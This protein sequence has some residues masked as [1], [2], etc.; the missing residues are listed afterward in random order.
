MYR[1]GEIQ[2]LT[3]RVKV[4]RE[5][6]KDLQRARLRLAGVECELEDLM[7]KIAQLELEVEAERGDVDALR[8]G[9]LRG[10]ILELFG[11]HDSRLKAE[12][13]ELL[14]AALIYDAAVEQRAAAQKQ[15]TELVA[16]IE[17]LGDVLG[18]A[19]R[20]YR[21]LDKYV[22]AHPDSVEALEADLTTM[23]RG[24]GPVA[25]VSLRPEWQR[26]MDA[27]RAPVEV[28]MPDELGPSRWSPSRYKAIAALTALSDDRSVTVLGESRQEH[29]RPSSSA[30]D[31]EL[32]QALDAAGQAL[33][34][35]T[36][37]REVVLGE[38]WK[39]EHARRVEQIT[40]AV[41][42]AQTSLG[43]FVHEVSDVYLIYPLYGSF[44]ELVLAAL[45]TA[46]DEKV[47]TNRVEIVRYINGWRELL[48]RYAVDLR[49]KVPST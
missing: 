2:R 5:R 4:A 24:G 48:E 21:E 15:R 38:R 41:V 3:E 46:H 14:Q 17:E 18:D 34:D 30:H 19:S 16:H 11:L 44:A 13:E 33:D 12:N 31:V 42:A 8:N 47:D 22:D 7:L 26:A 43:R 27:L 40:Q 35:L 29:G 23:I 20:A 32:I 6:V 28:E 36:V 45:R 37:L 39:R 9:T 10:S 1:Q 25:G 49:A